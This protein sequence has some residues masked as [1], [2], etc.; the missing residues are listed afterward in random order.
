M[1]N[2]NIGFVLIKALYYFYML[3]EYAIIG[4]CIISWLPL[5]RDNVIV[6][7]LVAV[8]EPIMGPIRR[9][10]A[11]SPLG[12]GMMIDFSPVLALLLLMFAY[13]VLASI[14]YG[15]FFWCLVKVIY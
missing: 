2:A 1:V 11:N 8:T 13:R 3:M 9:L 5:S 6:K 10:M 12:R 15:V 7:I 4:R 14:L